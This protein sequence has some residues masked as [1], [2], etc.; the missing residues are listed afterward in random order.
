MGGKSTRPGSQPLGVDEERRRVIPIIKA[1][2]KEFPGSLISV[3]TYKAAV[4]E[5]ALDAGAHIVNDVW[6]LR[7]DPE[8][9]ERRGGPRLPADPDAQ[10]QQPVQRG[11]AV[12]AWQCLHRRGVC[13]LLADVKRS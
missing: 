3:D 1:L 2:A 9:R 4:A 7:A 13:D 12:A 8:L 6:G 11:S 5:E 10:P